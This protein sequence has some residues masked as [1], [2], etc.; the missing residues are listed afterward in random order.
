MWNC[1]LYITNLG[2]LVSRSGDWGE[3]ALIHNFRKGLDSR[4]L[5][6]FSSHPSRIDYL[7]DL[8]DNSLELD[9]RYS[10]RQKENSHFQEKNP[11]A[12][13]S[14]SSHPQDS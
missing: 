5:D 7:Q 12:C 10:E 6:K 1:F 8:M 11:E 13:K 2:V 4:I 3:R 9:P 14:V